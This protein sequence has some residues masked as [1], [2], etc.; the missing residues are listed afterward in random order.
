MQYSYK[1]QKWL[2]AKDL[3]TRLKTWLLCD[4]TELDDWSVYF[5]ESLQDEDLFLI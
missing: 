1:N 2:L 4:A 3:Q 5:S